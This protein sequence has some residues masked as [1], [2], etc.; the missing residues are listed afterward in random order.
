MASSTP[1]STFSPTNVE[2]LIAHVGGVPGARIRLSPVP[3]TATEADL[4][5]ACEDENRL[6]E[7]IDGVL[8]EK[9]MGTFESYLAILLS[10]HLTR[11][12]RENDLGIVLGEAGMLRFSP[13]RIYIPDISFIS[14]SQNP[15]QELRKQPVADLHPNLAVEVLSSS[16]TKSE[17]ENKRRDYFSWGVQLVWQLD[18]AARVMQ[19]FTEPDQ[20][21]TIDENGAL[22]G[23]EVLPGFILQL[24]RL[25]V[26]ADRSPRGK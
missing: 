2:Q 1:T 24:A 8:V 16:N 10:E 3:G 4:L 11:F 19:V 17:M 15:M 6:C 25:F 14:W 18:P 7:L 23:G 5:R 26:D 9:A 21:T 20:F 12:A 22:D 13:R